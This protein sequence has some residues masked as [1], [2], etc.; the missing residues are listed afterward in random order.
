[1][2]DKILTGIRCHTSDFCFKSSDENASPRF[3]R[4][5]YMFLNEWVT[6]CEPG[7]P[8]H[9][10]NW[11]SLA[12]AAPTISIAEPT[13]CLP[14][15]LFSFANPRSWINELAMPAPVLTLLLSYLCV[16]TL[17]FK[18]SFRCRVSVEDGWELWQ[19]VRKIN[20][21]GL[22]WHF[23]EAS[24]SFH[25]LPV[26]HSLSLSLLFCS[27]PSS[28]S[29][30]VPVLTLLTQ[31]MNPFHPVNWFLKKSKKE[32]LPPGVKYKLLDQ[33]WYYSSKS[34]SRGQLRSVN[35]LYSTI[36]PRSSLLLCSPF[37]VRRK[38]HCE[39]SVHGMWGILDFPRY[40]RSLLSSV[41]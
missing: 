12:L 20:I 26:I 34:R 8:F 18:E 36:H 16:I 22:P 31:P 17:E 39:S 30:T 24:V 33:R 1:M 41:L 15:L 38:Q 2:V 25:T 4:K 9:Q 11:C 29:S 19:C 21:F 5:S 28:P 35:L 23:E 32:F 40:L 10:D 6:I 27:F 7:L 3:F 13:L 14:R 37:K